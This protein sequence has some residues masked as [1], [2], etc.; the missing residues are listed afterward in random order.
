MTTKSLFSYRDG[1]ALLQH[2]GVRRSAV[3]G[4]AGHRIH[5]YVWKIGRTSMAPTCATGH[6]AA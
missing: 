6:F 3:T 2:A 4:S 1:I 5:A